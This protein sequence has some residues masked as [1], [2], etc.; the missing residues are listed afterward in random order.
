M[1]VFQDLSGR[2]PARPNLIVRG[3]V[4]LVIVAAAAY[5][6][7]G[8][9]TGKY[10]DHNSV[11]INTDAIGDGLKG[12]SE[13]KYLG[14]TVGEVAKVTPQDGG[15]SV[16]VN[17]ASS[18]D[19]QLHQG[20]AV[21]YTS[22]NAL[23]P[24]ALEILDAGQGV[25]IPSGGSVYVSKQQSEQTTVASFIRKTSKLVETLDQ[26]SF[27]AVTK[28]L[29]EDSQTFADA[30]KLMFQIAQL[31]Q[32]VQTRPLEQDIAIAADMSVGVA[33][34]MKPFIPGILKNVDIAEFFSHPEN[35][36]KTKSNLRDTGEVLFG[37]KGLGGLLTDNYPALSSL[38]DVVLDLARPVARSASSLVSTVYSIPQILDGIDK[39]TPVVDNRVQLQVALMVQTQPALQQALVVGDSK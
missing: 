37:P 29:V 34:F 5:F 4:V 39:A 33:D 35:I 18:H 30:G 3:L 22:A 12:G 11:T 28:F 17:L 14:F 38:L 8:N 16:E 20:M 32:D 7:V 9:A 36:V 23:G 21:N 25:P 2:A 15:A 27:N 31:T 6:L 10:E 19:I 13:V 24:T 1:A 26:P